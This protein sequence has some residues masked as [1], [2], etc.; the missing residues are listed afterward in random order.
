[1]APW[2]DFSQVLDTRWSST[3][4]T[5]NGDGLINELDFPEILFITHKDDNP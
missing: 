4:T 2:S 3:S 1:L 5:D